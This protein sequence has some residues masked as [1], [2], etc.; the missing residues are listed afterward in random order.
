MRARIKALVGLTAAGLAASTL[1]APAAH[2]SNGYFEFCNNHGNIPSPVSE[3]VAFPYRGWSTS[4]VIT[5]GV[6]EAKC[7]VTPLSGMAND[8]AVG[9]RLVNGQWLAVATTYFNDDGPEPTIF[10]F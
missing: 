6:S 5:S 3:Y 2:A 8:E 7:W 4:P 10:E 1:V 9:Y